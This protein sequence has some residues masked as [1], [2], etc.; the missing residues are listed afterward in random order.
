[1]EL[2]IHEKGHHDI[3]YGILNLN[4]PHPPPYYR[5]IWDYKYAN[6]ENIQR[7]ISMFERQKAFKNKNTNEMTRIL[8]DTLMNIF[9]NFILHKTEIFDCK[10]PEWM[11]SFIIFSPEKER[12]TLKDFIQGLLSK[13]KKNI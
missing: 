9:K 5:E 2:T 8:T 6:T 1:M 7:A 11:N 12:S 4:L 3:I 10:Y 13:Q